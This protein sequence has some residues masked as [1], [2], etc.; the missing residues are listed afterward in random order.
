MSDSRRRLLQ[1]WKERQIAAKYR[2]DGGP[3]SGNWGHAG[4]KGQRGGSAPGGGSQHRYIGPS[5]DYTSFAKVKSA[6]AKP[7]DF[8]HEELSSLPGGSIVIAGSQVYCTLKLSSSS[9]STYFD[10]EFKVVSAQK[11]LDQVK[12]NGGKAKVAIPSTDEDTMMAFAGLKKP[13]EQNP[14]DLKQP[15][16]APPAQNATANAEQPI[17]YGSLST[18]S[19]QDK[20]DST[21]ILKGA[22]SLEVFGPV[23]EK[24]W[25]TMS[26]EDKEI[27]YAYTK[28]S[29]FVNEPLHGVPYLGPKP[30]DGVTAINSLTKSIDN[31]LTPQDC[32]MFHGVN[33][34]GFKSLMGLKDLSDDSLDSAIGKVGKDDGFVSCGVEEGK[35]LLH[36][37]VNMRIFVPQG[38][39][40]LYV[41]PFSS[42]G[43]GACSSSWNG[44][45]TQKTVGDECE[46]ILQR[47][48]GYHMLSWKKENGKILADFALVGQDYSDCTEAKFGKYTKKVPKD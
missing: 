36:H 41:E 17:E 24:T 18:Q 19:L 25:A 14:A 31:S 37:T 34:E 10:S 4:V 27:A 13:A 28:G 21:P 2:S 23:T 33:Q 5:G 40:C 46:G 20:L 47:G 32:V 44:K 11:V 35:G 38:S 39:K 3:G 48:G 12:L 1:Q 15:V 16:Q 9:H 7:H 6:Y 8:S 43:D 29:L 26:T 30:I 22:K 42:W 45:V